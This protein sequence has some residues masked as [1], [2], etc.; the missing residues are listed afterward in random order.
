VLDAAAALLV[1][2]VLAGEPLLE[3]V[4]EMH[5]VGRDLGL[6]VVEHRG[7]DLVGEARRHAVMPSSVPA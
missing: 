7:Q 6:V 2:Q 4:H 5:R 3:D 1:R